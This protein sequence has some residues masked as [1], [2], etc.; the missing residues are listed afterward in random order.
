MHL[1][2]TEITTI[3]FINDYIYIIAGSNNSH[4]YDLDLL[5]VLKDRIFEI[6]IVTK[7]SKFVYETF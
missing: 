4:R 7:P 3:I 5:N 2:A 6:T 1:P